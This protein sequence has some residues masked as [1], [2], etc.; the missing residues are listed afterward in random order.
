M[1]AIMSVRH[2][3]FVNLFKLDISQNCKKIS[4]EGLF[5]SI[6]FYF[7]NPW[8][9]PKVYQKLGK[10]RREKIIIIITL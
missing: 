2:F 1:I 5:Y 7:L 8:K 6:F 3:Q 9:I 4:A 10:E